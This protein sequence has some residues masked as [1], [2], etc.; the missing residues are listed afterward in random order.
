MRIDVLGVAFDSITMSQAVAAGLALL[1]ATGGHYVVTPNAEI[2]VTTREDALAREAFAKADLVLP[3][4]VGIIKGANMLGR[5]LKERVTG[6]D[7]AQHLM[8]AVSGKRLFLYGAA[9]GIAEIAAKKLMETYKGLTVCGWRD[10]Y[11]KDAD[12]ILSDIQAQKPDL[13]FVCLGAPKQEKWMLAH[14]D[15]VGN[16]LML[17]LGGC[18][19]VWS[20]KL[21]RAPDI[22]IKL[23]L[24]WLYRFIKQPT[25][26]NR[27]MRLPYFLWLVR[28]QQQGERS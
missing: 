16:C 17:G 3:D 6:I 1:D 11:D 5:P 9:P 15:V 14:K 20:G 13:L 8:Q 19:D 24:E 12:G 4:G 2:V 22:Y 21:N 18:L 25:R 7:F 23:G 10:G 27:M 28:K 26:L